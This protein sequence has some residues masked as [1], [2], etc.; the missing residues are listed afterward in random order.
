MVHEFEQT[1]AVTQNADSR[2]HVHH[3]DTHPF[4]SRYSHHVS[5][6]VKSRQSGNLFAEQQPQT[7]DIRKIIKTGSAERSVLEAYLKGQQQ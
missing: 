3:E 2:K 7:A 4:Q 5:E 1:A 6:V